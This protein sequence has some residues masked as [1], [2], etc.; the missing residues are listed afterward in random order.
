MGQ[1]AAGHRAG[2][3]PHC[4]QSECEVRSDGI[5]RHVARPPRRGGR[6]F[7]A[8][9]AVK[10][11]SPR[12]LVV[13]QQDGCVVRGIARHPARGGRRHRGAGREGLEVEIDVRPLARMAMPADRLRPSPGAVA[14]VKTPTTTPAA[15]LMRIQRS[16]V[17]TAMRT[18]T[19]DAIGAAVHAVLALHDVAATIRV[20]HA[21]SLPD[22][23]AGLGQRRLPAPGN[24]AAPERRMR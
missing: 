9:F 3:L 7:D 13:V 2:P 15:E 22:R 8:S 16:P 1:R 10:H 14:G 21:R 18:R 24:S 5:S 6:D 23:S 19:L 12:A 11:A 20:C 4:T 17:A